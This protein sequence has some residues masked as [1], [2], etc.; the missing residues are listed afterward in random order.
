[1]SDPEQ[2]I[3][4]TTLARKQPAHEVNQKNT[5]AQQST[6]ID[7]VSDIESVTIVEETVK[8]AAEMVRYTHPRRSF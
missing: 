8:T 3:N 1:L 6:T 2:L 4:A 5:K 7:M